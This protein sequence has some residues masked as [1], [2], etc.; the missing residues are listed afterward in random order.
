MNGAAL[1]SW[2]EIASYIGRGVRTV[3]RWELFFGLPV[4]RPAGRN[5][6][7]V[8]AL[9]SE[10]DAWLQ[11]RPVRDGLAEM[12]ESSPQDGNGSNGSGDGLYSNGHGDP[13]ALRKRIT[14]L[15]AELQSL[16]K[17][18]L[19]SRRSR[20]STGTTATMSTRTG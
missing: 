17:Q 3:Q 1:N 2:K 19:Q 5:R 20:P 9:P 6:S 15:E 11:S 10:I 16:R 12:N 13:A 14:E 8:Y 7:A 4:H 18:L